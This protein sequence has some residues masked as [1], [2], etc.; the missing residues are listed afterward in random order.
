[1]NQFLKD[2]YIDFNITEVVQTGDRYG[3]EIQ[4][5][6]KDESTVRFS[7]PFCDSAVE[8]EHSQKDHEKSL[9]NHSYI[10]D[11]DLRVSEFFEAWLNQI[12]KPKISKAVFSAYENAV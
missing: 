4:L 8:A 9:K 12:A 3:F 10:I 7:G 5:H 6:Y 11:P 2:R 1:M